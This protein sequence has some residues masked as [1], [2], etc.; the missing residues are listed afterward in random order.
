MRH[1][2]VGL[3][4]LVESWG[5]LPRK[6]FFIQRFHD[7]VEE[8]ITLIADPTLLAA[9]PTKHTILRARHSRLL[10][11]DDRPGDA[12]ASAHS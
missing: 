10:H 12:R 7:C 6:G 9:E 11:T 8:S 5:F 3:L 4:Q 1:W 2:E